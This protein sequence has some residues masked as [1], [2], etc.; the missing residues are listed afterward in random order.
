MSVQNREQ[1]IDYFNNLNIPIIENPTYKTFNFPHTNKEQ[2]ENFNN[3]LVYLPSLAIM[4]D[5]EIT[6]LAIL[7]N[8]YYSKNK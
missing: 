4:T 5:T 7:L 1:F 8:N 2:Y 6:Y 3:T